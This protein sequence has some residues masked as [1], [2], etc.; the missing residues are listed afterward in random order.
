MRKK[1]G[2]ADL[3]IGILGKVP[4]HVDRVLVEDLILINAE[5][6]TDI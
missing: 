5:W 2:R 1:K 6:G 4:G 3:E